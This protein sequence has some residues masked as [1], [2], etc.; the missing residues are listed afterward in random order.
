MPRAS[1]QLIVAVLVLGAGVAARPPQTSAPAGTPDLV[2]FDFIALGPGQRPVTDLTAD[3][4]A[5]KVDGRERAVVSLQYV[6][7]ADEV[8]NERVGL[9]APPLAAPFGTNVRSDDGRTVLIVVNHESIRA[10][11]ERPARDAAAK[12]IATLS[13]RDYVGLLTVPRGGMMVE[14]TRN[15]EDVRTALAQVVGA[16]P[17]S[18]PQALAAVRGIPGVSAGQVETSERACSARLT[19]EA[20]AGTLNTLATTEAPKTIVFIS[21]GLMPA[22][23]DAPASG[24]PGQCEIRPQHFEEVGTAAGAAR[25]HVYVIQPSDLIAD[26]ASTALSDPTSS[27]FTGADDM[28]QGLQNLAAVTGGELFKLTA[29][30]DPVFRRVS[31]E[32]AGYYIA[33]FEPLPAE[34]NGRPHRVEVRVSRPDVSVR[35]QSQITIAKPEGGDPSTITP[36]NMLR[37]ART[38][39]ALPL[40]AAAYASRLPDDSRLKIIAVAEPIDAS[41]RLVAAAAGLFDGKGK[42]IAQWTADRADLES[43]PLIGA[44]AGTPG[45]YRLRVAA[46]DANG[47]RGTVD[48]RF[49]AQLTNAG[50]VKLSEIALGTS[51]NGAFV[52]RLQFGTDPTAVVFLEIYGRLKAPSVRIELAEREDG[53]ALVSVPA[54]TTATGDGD[55]MLTVGALPIAALAPGDYVVRVMVTTDGRAVGSASRTLRKALR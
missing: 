44:L 15:H 31:R 4:I 52:P 20:L 55:R 37:Q 32:S 40:R 7:L 51:R 8:V 22:T 42:L 27:R 17:Q 48:Y 39:R 36:R 53:P 21:Q 26:T 28:L 45:P 47:R 9:L 23:R 29:S 14:P 2:A 30:A 10:G 50:P 35:A 3:Q 25:A 43:S 6:R 12:F 33:E 19:L 38:Y 11:R 16:A 24:P 34:R 54:T 13:P 18:T 5:L 41:T 49:R 46:V 1:L